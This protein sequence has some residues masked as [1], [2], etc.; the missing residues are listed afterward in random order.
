MLYI[1]VL[2]R[3]AGTW[4]PDWAYQYASMFCLPLF[5]SFLVV[6]AAYYLLF[7]HK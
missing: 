4:L 2:L 1:P 6:M 5:V 7:A 3:A